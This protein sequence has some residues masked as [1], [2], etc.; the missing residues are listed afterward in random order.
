V[1]LKVIMI[2]FI[3]GLLK[4]ILTTLKTSNCKRATALSI[5]V[6]IVYFSVILRDARRAERC[7]P[8]SFKR[9]AAGT[10]L[11]FHRSIRGNF[12]VNKV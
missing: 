6:I 7:F 8:C 11:N 2:I 9:E 4:H 3:C 12:M 10:E 5:F 1:V